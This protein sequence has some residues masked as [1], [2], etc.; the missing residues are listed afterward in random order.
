VAR[1]TTTYT[2][3]LT[4]TDN[5]SPPMSGTDS[6]NV[7]ARVT[8]INLI[9]SL[10]ADRGTQSNGNR[11]GCVYCHRA[12]GQESNSP[13]D[14]YQ[15]AYQWRSQTSSKLATGGSMRKYL[16]TGEPDMVINWISNGA[17]QTN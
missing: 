2:F 14:T 5:G 13:L 16:L 10:Y 4:V 9:Q 1:T 12:G 8:Y 11:L 6:V 7:S 15:G 17:P 3:Q